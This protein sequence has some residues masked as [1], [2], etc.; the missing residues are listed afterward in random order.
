MC[1]VGV[2]VS[3]YLSLSGKGRAVG[4]GWSLINFF[5]L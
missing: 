5:C 1:R 2:G 3:G 4:W